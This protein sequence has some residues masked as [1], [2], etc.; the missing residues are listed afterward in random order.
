M[1]MPSRLRSDAGTL[2]RD[3]DVPAAD[4]QRSDR[5]DIGTEPGGDAPLDAAQIRLGGGDICSRQNS[6]VT[7]TGTP[8]KIASS[9][10]GRPSV[11]PGILMNRFGC[12]ARACSSLAAAMVRSGIVGQQRRNLERYPAVDAAGPPAHRPKHLGGL[13][14]VLDRQ[15]EKQFFARL[16]FVELRPDRRIVGGAVADGLIEDR[17]VRRQSGHRQLVDVALQRADVSRSRVMLSSQML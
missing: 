1:A 14:Q 3:G 15:F 11:V 2:A 7:L 13:C 17:R 10:A 12:C 16:A 5:A 9:I 4:E 8:A 6:N